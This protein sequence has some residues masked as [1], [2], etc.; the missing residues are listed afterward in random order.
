MPT[1]TFFHL[2]KEKRE[3]LVEA[4]WAEFTRVPFAEVSINK[5]IFRARIP[6]GSFYQYFDDKHDLFGYLLSDVRDYFIHMLEEILRSTSGDLTAMPIVAFDRFIKQCGSSDPVLSHCLSIL[7]INAGMDLQQIFPRK[8]ECIPPSI[9][10]LL[11]LSLLRRQD[12]TFVG[13][14]FFLVLATV[15]K[16]I[17]DTLSFPDQWAQER[18]TLLDRVEI[19]RYGVLKNPIQ[20]IQQGGNKP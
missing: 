4:A 14:V 10:Q 20:P 8:Q 7:R 5:I 2:P 11:D 19:L 12:L 3:R 17:M 9:L 13:N 1:S 15:G 18:Q 16:A 6:R